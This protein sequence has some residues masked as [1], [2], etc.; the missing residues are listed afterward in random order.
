MRF[1]TLPA[2]SLL[3]LALTVDAAQ[4]SAPDTLSTPDTPTSTPPSFFRRWFG[5]PYGGG[6]SAATPPLYSTES[7]HLHS[8]FF[9]ENIEGI[10][11]M[12][13]YEEM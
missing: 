6:P 10:I 7:T 5:L 2:L 3:A 1:A 4:A 12:E 8:G 13:F 9:N 11:C